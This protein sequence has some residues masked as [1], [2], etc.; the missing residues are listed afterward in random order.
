MLGFSFLSLFSSV[1]GSTEVSQLRGVSNIPPFQYDAPFFA[2]M[3]VPSVR[4]TCVLLGAD[5]SFLSVSQDSHSEETWTPIDGKFN[6]MHMYLEPS[7]FGLRGYCADLLQPGNANA[8]LEAVL[9]EFIPS[10]TSEQM[11][12]YLASPPWGVMPGLHCL[13]Y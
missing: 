12:A 7:I 8:L 10:L 4:P 5:G 1:F 2:V 6:G 11:I 9:P 3:Q 13:Q